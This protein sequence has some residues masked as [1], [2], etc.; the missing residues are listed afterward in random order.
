MSFFERA[1]NTLRIGPQSLLGV[2]QLSVLRRSCA[3]TCF[4]YGFIFGFKLVR[5]QNFSG[6]VC[7]K[8][9]GVDKYGSLYDFPAPTLAKVVEIGGTTTNEVKNLSEV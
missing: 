3:T 2:L 4:P 6:N 5:I 1:R 8:F 7:A 9:A